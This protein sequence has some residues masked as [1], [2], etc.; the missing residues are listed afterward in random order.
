MMMIIMM[1]NYNDVD[2][3][4]TNYNIILSYLPYLYIN[5]SSSFKIGSFG[6]KKNGP[7]VVSTLL[8]IDM[9]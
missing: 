5:L 1:I 9:M 8:I 4:S 3:N 7:F 6:D 2:V